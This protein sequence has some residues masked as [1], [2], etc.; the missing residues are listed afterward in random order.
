M[1]ALI[2]TA[3]LAAAVAAPACAQEADV[4]TAKVSY[5]DVDF[6]DRGQVRD[7]YARLQMAAQRVCAQEDR[8]LATHQYARTCERDAV[9]GAV[10]QINRSELYALH[11]AP[12]TRV[13]RR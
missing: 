9:D 10:R 2:L 12:A 4:R 13:A 5:R 8:S 6:A 3:A 7:L 11:G 1:K